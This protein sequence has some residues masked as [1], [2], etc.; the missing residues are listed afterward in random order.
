VKLL[1]RIL[2]LRI[3]TQVVAILGITLVVNTLALLIPHF[4]VFKVTLGFAWLILLPGWLITQI[5]RIHTGRAWEQ[6]SFVTGFG[7]LSAM[8]VGLLTNTL[9]PLIGD[10][11]PLDVFGL[12]LGYDLALIGLT[13]AYAL[14]RRGTQLK[15]RLPKLNLP[16]LG[17]AAAGLPVVAL[18]VLGATALNNGGSN[19]LTV[20][21]LVYATIY[22][23]VMVYFRDKLPESA[24]LMGLYCVALAALLMTSLRGWYTTGHDVQ[25]EQRVFLLAL[26]G[27]HWNIASLR[28][29]YNACLSIT[30]LPA[31]FRQVLGVNETY[32]YKTLYQIIFAL[33]PVIA[34]A[35]S[36]RHVGKLAALLGSIYFIAFPTYF[37]DMPM[38]NRQETAFL[39][40]ALIFLVLFNARTSVMRRRFLVALLGVG[41]VLS[42]YSTTYTMI[43]LFAIVIFTR[44]LL[45]LSA[46]YIHR[47]KLVRALGLSRWK[48]YRLAPVGLGLILMLV[49]LSYIW[50]TQLTN[51]GDNISRV[52]LETL[53]SIQSGIKSDSRSSDTNYSIFGKPKLTDQQRIDSYIAKDLPI[54]RARAGEENLYPATTYKNYKPVIAQPEMLP[55]TPAGTLMQSTG[56]NVEK[57]NNVVRQG[58]AVFLQLM[59]LV[60]LFL[61]FFVRPYKSQID[62][63]YRLFQLA[64][65]GFVAAII[66][67]PILS[68]EYGLLRA[69]Q[70]ILMTGG[71]VIALATLRIIPRRFV[72]VS[73]VFAATLAIGFF[74]SSTGLITNALGGYPPQM[75]L[76][77][78]GK[79]YDLYYAH[80]G[81]Q[82]ALSWLSVAVQHPASPNEVSIG[83]ETDRYTQARVSQF[84]DLDVHDNIYP[85]SLNKNAYVFVGSTTL[86]QHTAT[87][88]YNGDPL[89]Y[90]YPIQFLDDNKDLLYANSGARVY[91]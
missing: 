46:R 52:G 61:I 80:P 67:L 89:S 53:R 15:L 25:R 43:A 3:S 51:T 68:A 91:R 11:Q 76:A 63:E 45:R 84:S 38:L 77:N 10:P 41:V 28:D 34:F 74:A 42:H 18:A 22:L 33:V 73:R 37:G 2:A 65:F 5:L 36:R 60:G 75:H 79:Y 54:Q 48:N 88:Y 9:L 29:A 7:V 1:K 30:I 66:L 50:S 78:S 86:L 40:V 35:V 31:A 12:L 47:P 81:E 17:F 62:N 59:L 70:Q 90:N 23:G 57:F 44:F 71:A 39:F 14:R 24:L 58:S 82:A 13:L 64:G 21:M 72:R 83:I 55:L 56:L 49:S 26:Q 6:L 27:L 32:V 4:D 16:A 8:L 69:F 85:G 19:A 20:I 87:V